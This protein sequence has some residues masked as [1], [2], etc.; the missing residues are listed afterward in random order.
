MGMGE[1]LANFDSTVAAIRAIVDPERFNIS[2]R[3]VTVS[4]VGLPRQIVRLAGLELPIKLALSLHAPNDALRR[5][6]IPA[7]KRY[8]LEAV[9]AAARRFYEVRKREVTLE[10][11]LLGGVN[12][13][14]VCAE[15]LARLAG[16]VRCKVNL[17]PYN[18]VPALPYR[19]PAQARV[20]AFAGRLARKGVKVSIRRPRGL[21][22]QAA[23][24]QLRGRWAD[25]SARI[26]DRTKN[27]KSP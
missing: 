24:G 11:V 15:G 12:D 23:C 9:L 7:A 18:P 8:P 1:P 6:L 19:R 17:I 26:D 2:A 5:E 20:R 16:R 3:S 25:R 27:P 13:T 10:Y 22:S 21:S 4:T 14:N